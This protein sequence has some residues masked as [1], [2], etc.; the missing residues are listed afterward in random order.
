MKA[1][2]A[3]T[4]ARGCFEVSGESARLQQLGGWLVATTPTHRDEASLFRAQPQLLA[5]V[6]AM[7]GGRLRAEVPCRRDVGASFLLVHAALETSL[8]QIAGIEHTPREPARHRLGEVS[9]LLESSGY[10][11]AESAD[12]FDVTLDDDLYSPGKARVA[13][14]GDSLAFSTELARAEN[15]STI[16]ALEHFLLALNGRL[17]FARGSLRETIAV[18]EV[19]FP[20][21]SAN[22]E[23]AATALDAL[24]V[25]VEFAQRECRA[26]QSSSLAERYLTFHQLTQGGKSI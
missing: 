26:L 17:R 21:A 22:A 12:G 24:R 10:C 6:K 9:A 25:G 14:L 7:R 11:W 15:V 16:R 2:A 3:T 20:A 4:I 19:V 1:S 23:L 13:I 8:R 5:P 18:L